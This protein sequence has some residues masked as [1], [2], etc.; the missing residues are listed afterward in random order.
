MRCGDPSTHNP[1][2]VA[3]LH[4]HI[5]AD[6]GRPIGAIGVFV[7]DDESGTDCL[8]LLHGQHNFPGS[9]GHS[10]DR[11]VTMGFEG[12][13]YGMDICTLAFDPT[14]MAITDDVIVPGTIDRVQKLLSEETGRDKLPPFKATDT[15]IRTTK[16]RCMGYFPIEVL[17]PH[18]GAELT[19]CQ[20]FELVVPSL[21]DAGL[22]VACSGLIYFITVALIQPTEDD[23]APLTVHAQ[24]GKAGHLPGPVAIH[25]RREHILYRDLPYL[26]PLTT[27]AATSDPTLID[28]ARGMR[29]MVSEARVNRNDRA[30]N[31]D[32]SQ[33]PNTVRENMGDTIMDRLPLL[34]LSTC[35][36]ELPQIYQE[37]DARARG[38]SERW[39]IQQEVEA[40][41]AFLNVPVFEVTLDQV[42]ALKNF[43]LSG[44]TY[45]DI[46]FGLL[47]FSITP[48]D[49]TSSQARA[50]LV[51]DRIRADAFYLGG[52]Q[53][54]EWSHCWPK[55][56]SRPT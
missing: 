54:R 24:A 19:A 18:L 7:T 15:N 44:S 12:D 33:R 25:Y 21:I 36:K 2:P 29:N 23:E 42:M 50:I 6:F 51:A 31:R 46:G 49:T 52:N 16:T 38:A 9:P 11:M 10:R 41:C 1:L 20:D 30:A 22:D 48:A 8:K 37:W 27:R 13:F 26:L 40:S 43:R 39:V 35:G 32:E 34:C 3:E 45:F 56:G 14:Q 55:R 28:V 5:L 4:Q 53:P 17:A 47:P